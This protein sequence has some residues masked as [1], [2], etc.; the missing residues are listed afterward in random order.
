ME[1]G[2]VKWFDELKGFGFITSDIGNKDIFVHQSDLVVLGQVLEKGDR[3]EYE[4]IHTAKGLEAKNVRLV[5]E[6]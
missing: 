3:V 2:T 6:S 4:I 1:R 5:E